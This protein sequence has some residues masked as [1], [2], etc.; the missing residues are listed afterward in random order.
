MAS[1]SRTQLA[2]MSSMFFIVFLTISPRPSMPFVHNSF[3]LPVPSSPEETW[4]YSAIVDSEGAFLLQW[5]PLEEEI[6][7]RLTVQT[8]GYISFGLSHT[9]DLRQADIVV[10]WVH[11]GKVYLQDRHAIGHQEPEVDE[12]QN[13]VLESGFENETHT[14]LV[15]SRPYD[16]CDEDDFVITSDTAVV[17]WGYHPDDPVNPEHSQPRMHYHSSKQGSTNVV[18]LER[19]EKELSKNLL[20]AYVEQWRPAYQYPRVSNT[21]LLTSQYVEIPAATDTTMWCMFKRPDIAFKHHIVKYEP[22]IKPGHEEMIQ[23]MMVYECTSLSP[24]V[25]QALEDIVDQKTH[26]CNHGTMKSLTYSC[27]HVMAAWTKGSKGFSYPDDVGYP[28]EPNGAKFFMLEIQY[29]SVDRTVWD[30]AG[31]KLLYTPNLRLHDAGILNTGIAPSWKH[32]VPPRQRVVLSQGHCVGECTKEALPPTGIHVFGALHSTH[33]LGRKI[34]VRHL[35]NDHEMKPIT[36]DINH[37]P[38]YTDFRIFRHTRQILPGD[39]LLTECQYNSMNHGQ[40]TLGGNKAHDETCQAF[41]LYWPKVDL[42]TCQ[43]TP[44]LNTVLTSL[45]VQEMEIDSK[46]M[47]I[48]APASLLGKSLEWRLLNH[49][50]RKQFRFFQ[51]TVSD[52]QFNPT[53]HY[54]GKRVVPELEDINYSPPRIVIPWT[55]RNKCISKQKRHNHFKE[56]NEPKVAGLHSEK[57]FMN[58]SKKQKKPIKIVDAESSDQDHIMMPINRNYGEKGTE[59]VLSHPPMPVRSQ[60]KEKLWEMEMDLEAEVHKKYR[61]IYLE[62]VELN[63]QPE[64]FSDN[65]G[66]QYGYHSYSSSWKIKVDLNLFGLTIAAFVSWAVI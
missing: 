59:I 60:L 31:L 64:N 34:R 30:A 17:L 58:D 56:K 61:D 21:W 50:W 42:S 23:N 48:S 44:S 13:W 51:S 65:N 10:G 52:G 3:N 2:R 45:G 57:E 63:N 49:N 62:T 46:P 53:C 25:D 22:V 33:S 19:G 47:K 37:N 11:S 28:L 18:L 6:M 24:E 16:T 40:I 4:L 38:N 41:L 27:N 36:Q 43:S 32:M 66:A 54:R 26:K 12:K 7:F 39:H 14:I 1:S 20:A 8:T 5:T 35:R 55:A 29:R 9:H 15:I